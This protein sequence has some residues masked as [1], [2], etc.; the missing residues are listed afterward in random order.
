MLLS[1][2]SVPDIGHRHWSPLFA[3]FPGDQVHVHTAP[4]YADAMAKTLGTI[5]PP[6][7]KN[8]LSTPFF[9]L[10]AVNRVN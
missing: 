1:K 4:L 5:F 3:L 9:A 10:V 7:K 6:E 8:K 2:R